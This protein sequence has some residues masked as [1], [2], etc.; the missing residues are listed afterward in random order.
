MQLQ[1]HSPRSARMH[2]VAVQE[3]GRAGDASLLLGY[4]LPPRTFSTRCPPPT[5]LTTDQPEVRAVPLT[6]PFI[7]SAVMSL[8]MASSSPPGSAA[9]RSSEIV[10]P[11]RRFLVSCRLHRRHRRSYEQMMKHLDDATRSMKGSESDSAP[12]DNWAVRPARFGMWRT[13]E[14][15][16]IAE[17]CASE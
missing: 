9:W 15:E 8:L 17:W 6:A 16:H 1:L 4:L 13:P 3:R 7:Q 11:H 12:L 14:G 2:L 5:C 10:V